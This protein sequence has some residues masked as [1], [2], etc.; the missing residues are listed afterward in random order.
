MDD[1]M[2]DGGMMVDDMIDD[3][4]MDGW[5]RNMSGEGERER[6]RGVSE[7]KLKNDDAR[8]A[9]VHLSCTA[10]VQKK[11]HIT[12]PKKT[13]G[14]EHKAERRYR[15]SWQKRDWAKTRPTEYQRV[16]YTDT[17]FHPAPAW[18]LEIGRNADIGN[19]HAGFYLSTYVQQARVSCRKS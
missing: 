12:R 16:A 17:V 10:A 18:A 6:E 15:G 14:M 5:R 8:G 13:G 1:T 9:G 3:G 2:D 11:A 7:R 19:K 4:R